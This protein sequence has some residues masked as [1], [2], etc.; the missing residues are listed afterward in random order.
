MTG[1][2]EKKGILFQVYLLKLLTSDDFPQP[3]YLLIGKNQTKE[4][5]NSK[6]KRVQNLISFPTEH[7]ST[8]RAS[9]S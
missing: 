7:I 5:A 4:A 8:S 1:L 9:R 2:Q 6:F 3:C